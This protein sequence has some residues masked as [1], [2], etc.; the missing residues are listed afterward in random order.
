MKCPHKMDMAQKKNSSKKVWVENDTN[1]TRVRIRTYLILAY[2]KYIIKIIPA[3]QYF[4]HYV[5]FT[6]E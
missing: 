4:C 3:I 6:I 2:R 1:S 5:H